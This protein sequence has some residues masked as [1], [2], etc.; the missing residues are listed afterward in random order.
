MSGDDLKPT[1]NEEWYM[2][3]DEMSDTSVGYINASGD[4]RGTDSGTTHRVTEAFNKDLLVKDGDVVDELG[5]CFDGVCSIGPADP[6]HDQMVLRNLGAL[7]GL[8]PEAP[9]DGSEPEK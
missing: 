4:T 2:L 5:M 3:K 9:G 6:G 1:K 7:T 8:R